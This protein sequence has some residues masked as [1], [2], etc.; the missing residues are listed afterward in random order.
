MG[1]QRKEG[2]GVRQESKTWILAQKSPKAPHHQKERTH[3]HKEHTLN[4]NLLFTLLANSSVIALSNYGELA[5]PLPA[6]HYIGQD[7]VCKLW[8]DLS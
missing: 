8:I 7:L 2:H 1:R 4:V 5:Q 6:G 3:G